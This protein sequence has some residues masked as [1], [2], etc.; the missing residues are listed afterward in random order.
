MSTIETIGPTEEK[1]SRSF[2]RYVNC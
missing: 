2:L 1:L